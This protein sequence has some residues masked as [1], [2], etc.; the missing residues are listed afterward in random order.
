LRV[1][2]RLD[3][4]GS[5][6]MRNL[7]NVGALLVASQKYLDRVGRPKTPEDIASHTT[8]SIS[9][10]EVHQRW[11]LHG[12]NGEVRRVD[13]QPRLAGFDFPLL[14]SMAKDGFGI[15]ML[16]ET[17]CAEAVRS[18]ELEVVLPDW[19]LPQGI[20]HAVFASRRG[21]LPAVRVF[22]DFL[23]ERL[24]RE[25]ERSRLDCGGDCGKLAEKIKRVQQPALVAEAG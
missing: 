5:L 11:E 24:P 13:L 4:D 16:P 18:G 3:D 17:V 1:R 22:I 20:C 10:D 14:K 7:A 23:A 2:S 25:I 21:L 15:T 8:M 12:P 6:V 19:T 9:E